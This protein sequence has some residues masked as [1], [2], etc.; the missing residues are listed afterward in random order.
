M[1]YYIR[2]TSEKQMY[3]NELNDLRKDLGKD[4]K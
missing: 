4:F 3:I 2:N 1:I